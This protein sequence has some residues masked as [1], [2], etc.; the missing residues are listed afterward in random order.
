MNNNEENVNEIKEIIKN[1]EA[2]IKN[3]LLFKINE[4]Q[5]ELEK[6]NNELIQVEKTSI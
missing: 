5:N 3:I 2:E 1:K 6:K 4:L